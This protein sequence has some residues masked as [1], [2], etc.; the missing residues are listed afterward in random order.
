M[1]RFLVFSLCC[2]FGCSVLAY[3]LKNEKLAQIKKSL[4]RARAYLN[5]TP[6]EEVGSL[7]LKHMLTPS[8]VKDSTIPA[9]DAYRRLF[10]IKFT[11]KDLILK[12]RSDIN[13]AADVEKLLE[14]NKLVLKN[15]FYAINDKY[16]KA[17]LDP[18]DDILVKALYCDVLGYDHIDWAILERLRDRRGDYYDTHQ[19]LALLMLEENGCYVQDKIERAKDLVV[20]DIVEAQHNDAQNPDTAFNDLFAE[21]LACIYWAG[22]GELV[23]PRWIDIILKAQLKD[24][25]W[26]GI[27]GLTFSGTHPSSLAAMGLRYFSEQGSQ[28]IKFYQR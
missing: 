11:P 22:K 9:D 2:L 3:S 7:Y 26:P 1:N 10:G 13:S 25:G 16:K 15:Y 23:S 21:R 24:G 19:L 14:K 28:P 12:R 17:Y 8:P 6:P 18:W 4:E 5:S 20:K 27:N